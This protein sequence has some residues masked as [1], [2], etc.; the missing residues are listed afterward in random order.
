LILTST[1]EGSSIAYQV[2]DAIGG[3]RWKLYSQ[4]L[5]MGSFKK[6]AARAVRIGF[7]TSDISIY[8]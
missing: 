4:S 3:K 7:K 2:D 8:E 6:I 1:T 5:T